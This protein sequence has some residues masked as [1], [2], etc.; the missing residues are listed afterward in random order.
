MDGRKVLCVTLLVCEM[1]E[2]HYATVGTGG[3]NVL[4]CSCTEE[5]RQSRQSLA[6]ILIMSEACKWMMAM[7]MTMMV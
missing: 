4:R 5:A 2:M 7:A 3:R 1:C 6:G